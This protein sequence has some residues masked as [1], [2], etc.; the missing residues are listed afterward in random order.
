MHDPLEHKGYDEALG[1][2]ACPRNLKRLQREDL[3]NLT[4]AFGN[5]K[6]FTLS[7]D[8]MVDLNFLNTHH[9]YQNI[10]VF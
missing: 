10:R 8:F 2:I 6:E 5:M 7:I 4:G 3:D 9:E 1:T